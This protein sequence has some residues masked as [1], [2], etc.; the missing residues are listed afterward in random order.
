V[1]LC[2][3]D[4]AAMIGAHASYMLEERMDRASTF[5]KQIEGIKFILLNIQYYSNV[6]DQREHAR[7]LR[8][9]EE[10]Y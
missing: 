5:G 8:V 10:L 9:K 7:T 4:T 1:N 6:F 3:Y 2:S